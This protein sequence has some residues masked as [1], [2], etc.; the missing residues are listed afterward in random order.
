MHIPY[1]EFC[2]M[3]GMSAGLGRLTYMSN[4][5]WRLSSEQ[6]WDIVSFNAYVAYIDGWHK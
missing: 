5:L 4:H 6:R 1:D 2:G 3:K